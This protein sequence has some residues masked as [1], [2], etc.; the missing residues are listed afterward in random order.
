MSIRHFAYIMLFVFSPVFAI[1]QQAETTKPELPPA[2]SETPPEAK[3]PDKAALENAFREKLI[4][5]V[6][7][8]G[9]QMTRTDGNTTADK[10]G[11]AR[12][13]QYTISKATKLA[14]DYWLIHA[15][16]EYA[17]KDV[18][19]PVP[20]RVVWAEE[21]PIITLDKMNLPG[22]GTYA[23]RVMIDGDFYAGTWFG[24]GYGGVMSGQ[25][26]KLPTQKNKDAKANKIEQRETN[27][28]Q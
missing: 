22:L 3:K 26:S 8:G 17:D 2:K 10:L 19:L 5:A 12:T 16:V 15:R 4:N 24:A 18:T 6:L 13:D 9:W 11:E 27:P 23:A 1:G 20:V 14:N 25:I 7:S 28:E 21:T